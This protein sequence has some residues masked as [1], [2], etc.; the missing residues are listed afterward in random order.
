MAATS[1]D[2]VFHHEGTELPDNPDDI[3]TLL[4]TVC[5]DYKQMRTVLK[6]VVT[7]MSNA[8]EQYTEGDMLQVLAEDE[9]QVVYRNEIYTGSESVLPECSDEDL[10]PARTRLDNIVPAA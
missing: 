4:D 10:E 1:I 8:D 7:E 6:E 3:E 2:G 5:G 9:A